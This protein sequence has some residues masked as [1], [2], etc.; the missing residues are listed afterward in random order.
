M[1]NMLGHQSEWASTTVSKGLTMA[2]R[3][4]EKCI[5][6][7]GH[8]FAESRWQ[9]EDRGLSPLPPHPYLNFN[10]V[11]TGIPFGKALV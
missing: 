5:P 3:G 11:T 4:K 8:C 1:K 10:T 2:L 9:L 7:R 6:I